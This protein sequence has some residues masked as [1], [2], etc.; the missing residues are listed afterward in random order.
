VNLGLTE[1]VNYSLTAP[2]KE[3]PLGV[4]PARYVQLANPISSERTHLRQ[5][6]LASVLE[7]AARNLRD[8]PGVRFFEIGAVY[9]ARAERPLPDEPRRLAIVLAGPRAPEH[10]DSQA[11]PPALDFFDLK[12]LLEGIA[13]GLQLGGVS[14]AP[15]ADARERLHP[16]Q[17]AAMRIGPT[18]LAEFGRLHPRLNP[19]YG[20]GRR[21]IL[22]ADFDL[23]ALMTA[24]PTRHALR[25]PS[26]FP[27]VRQDI[28]LVVDEALPAATVE[29]EIRAAGGELL[30]AVRLFDVFQGGALPAGKKSL[31]YALTFQAD[32]RTLTD[33]DAARVQEKIVRRCEKALGAALRA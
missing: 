15:L 4:D 10:W 28:A 32:E 29:A 16:G 26:P 31:A 27:P 21:A 24:T 2:E 11:A 8:R 23:E 17:A 19:H 12:G 33:K 1:V 9:Q 30:R 18:L 6:L 3:Q 14:Y 20:L 25:P 7:A 13:A 22:V 5:S